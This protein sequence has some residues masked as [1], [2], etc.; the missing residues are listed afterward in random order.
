LPFLYVRALQ[1]ENL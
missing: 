1:I